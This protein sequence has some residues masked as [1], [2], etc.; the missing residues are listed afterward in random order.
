MA[1]ETRHVTMIVHGRVQG[2]GYRAFTLRYAR[3]LGVNAWPENM[4][5]GSV[6]VEAV[7]R[8]DRM[9]LFIQ[10]LRSGPPSARVD[11]VEVQERS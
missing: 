10:M 7:G 3:S 9:D 11:R 2:V 6:R 4:P 5:D 1:D 8:P